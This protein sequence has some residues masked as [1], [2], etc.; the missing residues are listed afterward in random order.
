LP[1][2]Q[3]QGVCHKLEE[4]PHGPSRHPVLFVNYGGNL[5]TLKEMPAN[6]GKLEYDVLSKIDSL[7][8]PCVLPIGYAQ[9]DTPGSNHSVLITRYLD[10]S[11]PFRSL[12]IGPRLIQYQNHL[13][14]AIAGLLVQLH[15]ADVFW[16]DCSLSN[17]L[18]RR[19][20]GALRAYLVDAETAEVFTDDISPGLRYDD[21]L[22]M[23]ENITGELADLAAEGYFSTE[24]PYSEAGAYIRL[25][26]QR[27]W[28]EITHEEYINPQEHFRIQERIRA[29]NNLGFSVGD[30]ELQNTTSGNQLRLRVQVTDRNFHRDLLLN[31]T[32]IEAEEMQARKMMN[33]I[34]EI[35]AT[36]SQ[37]NN[38]S[39]SMSAA[40]Y[41]WQKTIYEPTN[42]RLKPFVK[43]DFDTAELY[44]QVLEHKWYLS[45]KERRDV[46]HVAAVDDYLRN[47]ASK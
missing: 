45:E 42:E 37:Q 20:A 38:H 10:Y 9:F 18:F 1:L 19:D 12:F 15:L 5:Y 22:R 24:A 26:Y 46:G 14:N 11:I 39:T 34:Q 7:H 35:K 27:L 13:L 47:V 28:E 2:S 25:S 16:G 17:T 32:G 8:L 44:C 43:P 4:V 36:L 30:V 31:L 3:W 6:A 41:H 33:E 21:L 40:A 23:E 29:L